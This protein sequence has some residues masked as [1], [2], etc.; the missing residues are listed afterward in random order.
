[1]RTTWILLALPALT[2]ACSSDNHSVAEEDLPSGVRA[3]FI[4]E[5]PYATIDHPTEKSNPNGPETYTVPYKR[6]DGTTGQAVYTPDGAV[7][8]DK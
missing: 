6:P 3:A 8:E 4:A 7:L 2:L 5:H 1:M